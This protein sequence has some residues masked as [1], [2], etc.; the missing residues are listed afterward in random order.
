LTA[1]VTSSLNG[2]R[3]LLPATDREDLS[4]DRLE[5]PPRALS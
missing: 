3:N 4:P 2:Q 1:G 5:R